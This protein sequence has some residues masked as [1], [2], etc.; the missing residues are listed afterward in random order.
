MR[1]TVVEGAPRLLPL[2]EPEAGEA[3]EKAFAADGIQVLTGTGVDSVAY[4]DGTFTVVV[5]EQELTADKLL[6]AAGRR[7][8][9]AGIGLETVG[10]DPEARVVETDERMR[11]GEKLWAVGDITGKGAYTHVSMYQAA[12]AIRDILGEDGPW[13]DYRAVTRATFTAPEVGACGLSEEQAREQLSSV[14]TATGDLGARGWIAKEDGLVKLVA[15][16][17]RGV[18]V[19]ATVVGPS[20]GELIG[21][22]ATAIHAEIPVPTLA[23]RPLRLS[24]VLPLPRDRPRLPRPLTPPNRALCSAEPCACGGSNRALC[25]I[26]HGWPAR[27]H[28]SAR[29]NAR[30]GP[31][32]RTVRPARTHGSARQNARFGGVGRADGRG[33]G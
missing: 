26:T 27:T 31:P 17:S 3:L 2:E 24:H 13:A 21:I 8:N 1:V 15:D 28:G 10:V 11:A 4:A 32:E 19:G 7:T 14:V 22:L 23:R 20:G 5:G 33:H 16:A 29:Q 6:V 25:A 18:L 12:V 30:L 9:L